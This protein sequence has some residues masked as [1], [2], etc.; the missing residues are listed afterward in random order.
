MTRSAVITLWESVTCTCMHAQM[1]MDI[2]LAWQL[3]GKCPQ[4]IYFQHWKCPTGLAMNPCNQ[5]TSTAAIHRC[6]PHRSTNA[7]HRDNHH[8]HAQD[9]FESPNPN[10]C[11]DNKIILKK[12]WQPKSCSHKQEKKLG[13]KSL[14][15]RQFSET[16]FIKNS[17]ISPHT[18]AKTRG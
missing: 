2:E 18:I 17:L 6:S 13:K 4:Q 10:A 7:T 12:A 5:P 1:E 8:E 15:P 9:A 3:W 14:G 11:Q 16:V